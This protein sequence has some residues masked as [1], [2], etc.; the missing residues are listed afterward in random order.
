VLEKILTSL[1]QDDML[2]HSLYTVALI[3]VGAAFS[4]LYDMSMSALLPPGQFGL[5]FSL[6]SLHTM[7]LV[8]SDSLLLAVAKFTSR[9]VAIEHTGR[10]H[11]L[12]QKL[13]KRTLLAS[14]IGFAVIAALSPLIADFL[15]I[16]TV[17]YPI[18]L[19]SFIIGVFGLAVNRGILQ[20]MQRFIPFGGLLAAG[21]FLKFAF[22]VLLVF[23]GMEIYGAVAALPIAFTIVFLLSFIFLR[24]LPGNRE[25]KADLTGFR[26]YA[27]MTL[28]AVLALTTLTNIDVVLAKHYFTDTV[29]G[30]YATLSLLGRIIFYAPMGIGLAMFPKTSQ[31]YES[32]GNHRKLF[33][34]GLLLTAG[35]A[36]AGLLLYGFF[37]EFIVGLL[38]GDKYPLVTPHLLKYA[39]AM[40]LFA[41]AYLMM[42]YLLSLNRRGVSWALLATV[43]AQVLLMVLYHDDIGQLTNIML[44][45]GGLAVVLQLPF[46]RWRG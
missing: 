37:G 45:C 2:R 10:I 27:G 35:T 41:V 1:K 25:E 26:A 44:T 29:A 22:G 16:E 6:V 39:A 46:Y 4:L 20:G 19:F 28:L 40:G 15:K 30:N 11:N 9:L 17:A 36:G 5:L 13:L 18:I 43:I 7:I 32:H 24:K 42:N 8:F 38:F 3:L 34:K 33:Y 23:L 31:L 14:F 12:W 21:H